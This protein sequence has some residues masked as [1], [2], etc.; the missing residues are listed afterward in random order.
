MSDL[1]VVGE[2]WEKK[3]GVVETEFAMGGW[4]GRGEVRCL[5]MTRACGRRFLAL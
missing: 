3:E 4:Q 5:E 1:A 2:A